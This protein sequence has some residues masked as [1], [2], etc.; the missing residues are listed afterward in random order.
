MPI[1]TR[2]MP[3]TSDGAVVLEELE[4]LGAPLVLVDAA[5]VDGEAIAHART[6]GGSVRRSSAAGISDPMP[7]TTPGTDWLFET[8]WIERAFF[9]RVV[10]ERANAAEDRRE[11]AES[12]RAVAFGRRHQH[13]LRRHRARAVERV[14]IAEAEEDEEVVVGFVGGDVGDQRGAG[15]TF[16]IE[17]RQLVAQ[18]VRWCE[19]LLRPL[20]EFDRVAL[21]GDRRSGAP[22][23]PCMVSRLRAA[24]SSRRCSRDARR[25]SAPRPVRAGR[26]A[27][28]HSAHAVRRR[29]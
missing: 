24:R 27:R 15:R 21:D 13:G 26:G 8:P 12:K 9:V 29:R 5:D 11:H 10:H 2:C 3:S 18:R 19:H 16:C 23:M 28:Q 25:W 7:T 1:S 22:G 6:S 4:Q 20:R 17:P 14:V